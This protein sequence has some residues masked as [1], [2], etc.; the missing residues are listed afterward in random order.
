MSPRL[1]GALP[2]L[3]A[4]LLVAVAGACSQGS[5]A[6]PDPP[7]AAAGEPGAG[8]ELV[9]DLEKDQRT[10]LYTVRASGEEPRQ[11]RVAKR[12]VRVFGVG[13]RIAATARR[14]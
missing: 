8:W 5:S 12:E 9:F 10:D 7:L 1:P 6:P 2:A 13:G 14:A 3:G 11:R 4:A